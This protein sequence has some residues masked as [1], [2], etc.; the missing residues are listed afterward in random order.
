MKFI[1]WLRKQLAT[2]FSIIGIG[3]T[4]YFSV[5]HIPTWYEDLRLKRVESANNSLINTIQEL[6]YN[7]QLL[8][9]EKLQTLVQGKE[10]K[11]NIRYPYSI[12]ELLVQTQERFMDSKFI[13][14]EQ[15]A[16]LFAEIGKLR[17]GLTLQQPSSKEVEKHVFWQKWISNSISLLG[18]IIALLGLIS[19]YQK[20]RQEKE[21]EVENT[22]EE[23][24]EKIAF[25]VREGVELASTVESI[26]KELIP[27][28][29]I[30]RYLGDRGFDFSVRLPDSSKIG[31]EIKYTETG[32]IP[33]RTI[34]QLIKAV[35]SSN[36]RGLLIA[37]ARLT[38]NAAKRLDLFNTKNPKIRISCI[39]FQDL[40]DL[41]S[42][43]ATYIKLMTD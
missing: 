19:V 1:S 38:F 13:P 8:N 3:L 2:I 7:E 26:F 35:S 42:Q 18:V 20:V 6:V 29:N 16:N 40:D 31:V 24:E 14:L 36:M 32:L 22:V 23:R 5:F 9:E 11:H 43:L 37:N 4:I 10:L 15:R 28:H 27:E 30:R 41:R 25:R 34:D 33:V 21:V 17:N 39:R 12:D